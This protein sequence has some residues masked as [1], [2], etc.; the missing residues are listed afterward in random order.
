MAGTAGTYIG[1]RLPLS[2]PIPVLSFRSLRSVLYP[3]QVNKLKAADDLG[4]VGSVLTFIDSYQCC[5]NNL[6]MEVGITR[7]P[8]M[9]AVGIPNFK[10][11]W[12]WRQ[13]NPF[14]Q[15]AESQLLCFKFESFR[16]GEGEAYK[17]QHNQSSL[18]KRTTGSN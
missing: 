5:L 15:E 9:I 3:V 16:L 10:P 4:Q 13:L 12:C 2:T 1:M 8:E 7:P 6:K 14:P 11:T 17:E 18:K